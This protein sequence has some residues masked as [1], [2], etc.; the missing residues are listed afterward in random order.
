VSKTKAND[1]SKLD[2]REAFQSAASDLG[3]AFV[4]GKRSSRDQVHMEH[5]PWKV[6]LDTY[7]VSQGQAT[8]TYTRVR[9]L[10]IARD[11]FTVS[12]TRKHVFT[13]VS[14]LLGFYGLLIGDQEF[15]RK[16]KIKSSNDRRARSLLG[17]RH[18]R[19][20]IMVQPSL[21]LEIRRLPWGRRRK[22]GDGVRA[23]V[24]QTT[25]VIK[26]PDRLVNY[27]RLVV[28]VLD[29]LVKV[30]GASNEPVLESR[31]YTLGRRV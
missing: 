27:V 11:D 13:R 14:E 30:G 10:Y 23:V 24:V 20:L 12:V 29:R 9:T 7:V 18:L 17:D 21:R 4:A 16:Y 28:A 1:K 25:G 22:R 3:A 6:T 31:T 15:E 19:E 26:E 5:G 2:R 8:I